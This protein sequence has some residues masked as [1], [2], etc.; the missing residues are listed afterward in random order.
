MNNKMAKN[1]NLSIIESKK[2]TKRTRTET[3]SWTQRAYRWE[4]GVGGMGE[5]GRGSG[6]T[7]RQLQRSRGDV[8]DSTGNGEDKEL[9]HMTA[10]HERWW[11]T[12]QGSEG[13]EGG[14]QRGKNQANY[15]SI[16][17]KI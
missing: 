5:E 14:G 17:N 2:Q 13:A 9:V 12:A 7:N 6:S 4:G 16:I 3:E 15:N 10:G 8:K 11:G 1:T